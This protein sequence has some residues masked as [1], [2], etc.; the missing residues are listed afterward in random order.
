MASF[1][2]LQS[3]AQ[4]A[5]PGSPQTGAEWSLSTTSFDNSFEREPYVGNGYIGRRVPAAGM[6]YLGDLGKVGWPIGTECI[7]SAIAAGVYA[8][9]ADGTF[10]H[11]KKQAIALIPNWS[12]LTFGDAVGR[13]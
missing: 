10:Y 2:T 5:A 1:S 12:T 13:R 3:R 7:A 11:D 8:K 6:G 9:V 4:D